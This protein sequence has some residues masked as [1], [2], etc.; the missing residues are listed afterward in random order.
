MANKDYYEILGVSKS[1]TKDDIKKAFRKLAHK[2]HPDKEGGDESRFKEVNEAYSVLGDD[3]KRA[4]YDAYGRTFSGSNGNGGAGFDP[5]G[6][7]FDFSGFANGQDFDLND[8]FGNIF[9]GGGQRVKRGRDISIDIELTFKEAIFGA[10]RSVLISKASQC[11]RCKGNGA[12][13]GT[14]KVT[15]T[16]CNGKGRIREM[17]RSIFGS[18][19]TE[20]TCD[21]CYGS[22]KMPKVKCK[23]CGGLG[24]VKKQQEVKIVIPAGIDNGEMIRLSGQGEAVPGGVSGDLYVKIHIR[25]DPTFVKDGND[26]RMD[27]KVKLSDALLGGEYSVATLDGDI[28]VKIPAGVAHG[29]V[30]RVKGKGVPIEKNKRGDLLIRVGIS[31]PGKLSGEAKRLVEALRKEGI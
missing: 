13:P 25:R 18:F 21:T 9:G 10:T 2:Y 19:A 29:E 24:V 28:K 1:A 4:E 14:E 17:R 6:F 31:L 16:T 7:G 15:C 23:E 8:I 12:E 20:T 3:K 11:D 30:L 22:G 26:I 5:N 27:L